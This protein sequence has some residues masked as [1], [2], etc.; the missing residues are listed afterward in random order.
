MSSDEVFLEALAAALEMIGLD[1]VMVGLAAAAIQGAPL[2][3]QAVDLLVRDTQRNR[4]KILELAVAVGAGKPVRVSELAQVETLVGGD[5]PVDIV[6]DRLPGGLTFAA[7][8]ARS[9]RVK[10]G[11][12][13]IRVAS[14]EDI[15]RSK[16]AANRPKDLAQLPILRETA[17]V[18]ARLS[19]KKK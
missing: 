3:A 7:V 11:P 16:V 1:A 9:H 18:L 14:L 19:Q 15:I 8:K 2:M 5:A 6:F 12:A 4:A 13:S 10:L 17:A